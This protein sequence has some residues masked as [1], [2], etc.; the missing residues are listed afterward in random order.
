[1]GLVALVEL[2]GAARLRRFD[3]G[4]ARILG[5]N[6]M[7]LAALLIAYAVF[8]IYSVLTGPGEYA[9]YA[10]SDP[11]LGQMLGPIE[12]LYRTIGLAVYATVIAVAVF[13]QGGMAVYYFSRAGHVRDYL[14]RTPAWVLA[15][16]KAGSFV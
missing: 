14:R 1:M 7:A 6:Q 4:A 15:V 11:Q 2:R 5:F 9:A 10:A 12:D 8:R 16:Q 3:A 13:F